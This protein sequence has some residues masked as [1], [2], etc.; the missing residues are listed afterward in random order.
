MP[1][2]IN[3]LTVKRTHDLDI[4]LKENRYDEPKE[5]FKFATDLLIDKKGIN[6]FKGLTICDFGCAAG[7]FLY[8][9]NSVMPESKLIG[10]DILEVLLAKA[11]KFIPDSEFK[12][13]SVLNTS[14]FAPNSVDISFLVGVHSIF[15]EFEE[16]FNNLIHWTKP[17]GSV[18]IIGTFNPYPVD[19]LI[20]YKL[21]QEEKLN[22]YESG[23]NLFSI[24]SVSNFLENHTKVESFAFEKFEIKIDL[25]QQVDPVRAWTFKSE[26]KRFLTNGLSVILPVY[27]LHINL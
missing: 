20:K 2:N 1:I 10:V 22:V 26:S 5:L 12:L 15:D 14:L 25:P 23:W 21:S 27:Y 6:F 18:N 19:V 8:H 11:K 4:Y 7:E 17:S 3:D 9:L 16:C 13:G 24:H